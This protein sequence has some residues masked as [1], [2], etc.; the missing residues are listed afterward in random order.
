MSPQA[1]ERRLAKAAAY[2]VSGAQSLIISRAF[3]DEPRTPE[4][5]QHAKDYVDHLVL[6][7]EDCDG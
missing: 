5:E 6:F 3:N 1:L 7:L 4:E 2:V